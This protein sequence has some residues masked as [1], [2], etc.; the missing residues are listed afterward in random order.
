GALRGKTDSARKVSY[1]KQYLREALASRLDPGTKLV[2]PRKRMGITMTLGLDPMLYRRG[3]ERRS[4]VD[5][6]L[7]TSGSMPQGVIDWVSELV[8]EIPG[9]FARFYMFDGI[10][11]KLVPGETVHGGGGTNFQNCVDVAE[12]N[13]QVEG[14]D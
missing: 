2:I 6:Y 1:W 14:D 13:Q 4:V 5:I 10:V 7:D 12:G 8:G 3:N 9:C 11:M